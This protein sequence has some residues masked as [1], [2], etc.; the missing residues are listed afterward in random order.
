MEQSRWPRCPSLKKPSG[1]VAVA[2]AR[3]SSYDGPVPLSQ[4]AIGH[5]SPSPTFGHELCTHATQTHAPVASTRSFPPQCGADSTV[6]VTSSC[7]CCIRAVNAEAF[8]TKPG[9]ML[10]MR[11]GC[12][13]VT[14]TC[15]VTWKRLM[16]QNNLNLTKMIIDAGHSSHRKRCGHD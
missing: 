13:C 6:P 8:C 11:I 14:E 7:W 9:L 5:E 15:E 1:L 12:P 10:Q 16:Q 2:Q 4:Q 3:C